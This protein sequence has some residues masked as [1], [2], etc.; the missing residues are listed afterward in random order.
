MAVL[1]EQLYGVCDNP[2][3]DILKD[4]YQC[5][6]VV[7]DLSGVLFGAPILPEN[8]GSCYDAGILVCPEVAGSLCTKFH[9]IWILNL[10]GWIGTIIATR[11]IPARVREPFRA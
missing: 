7:N 11:E 9:L 8:T 5:S 10:L 1:A 6:K 2:E 4:D 3:F